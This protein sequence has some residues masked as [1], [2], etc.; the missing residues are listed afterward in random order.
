MKYV[1]F[2]WQLLHAAAT[3][4]ICS[5]A[6][7]EQV[8]YFTVISATD[9]WCLRNKGFCRYTSVSFLRETHL[10]SAA[11]YSALMASGLL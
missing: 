8:S 5:M 6:Y 1:I 7:W 9:N 3:L 4:T 11:N 10:E 2:Q